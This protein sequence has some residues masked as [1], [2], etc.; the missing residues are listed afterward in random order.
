MALPVMI[1]I[2]HLHQNNA[3]QAGQRQAPEAKEVRGELDFLLRV[4]LVLEVGLRVG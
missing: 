3:R 4:G 1:S 2:S